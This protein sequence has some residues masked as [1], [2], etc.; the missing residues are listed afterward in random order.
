MFPKK[1]LGA[2]S[3]TKGQPENIF[4]L[5]FV[6]AAGGREKPIQIGKSAYPR[7]FKG[8]KDLMDFSNLGENFRVNKER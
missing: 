1:A 7:C 3:Q 8:I 6:N 4:F 5:F 2:G